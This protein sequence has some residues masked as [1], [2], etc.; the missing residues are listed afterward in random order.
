MTNDPKKPQHPGKVVLAEF[1]ANTKR[2][3]SVDDFPAE[4]RFVFLKN[5]F[6]VAPDKADEVVPVVKVDMIPLNDRDDMVPKDQAT[7]VMIKEY[8]PEGRPLRMTIMIKTNQQK[9]K[10]TK[11]QDP[12]RE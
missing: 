6:E 12:P 5:G 7:K 8:G 3:I 11:Q 4:K 1:P 10:D 2:E 9:N